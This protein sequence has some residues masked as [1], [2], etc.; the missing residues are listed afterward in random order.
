MSSPPTGP[1]GPSPRPPGP[2]TGRSRTGLVV[3]VV[4]LVVVIAAV[5]ALATIPVAHSDSY[6]F[7]SSTNSGTSVTSFNDSSARSICPSG[8]ASFTF[9]SSGLTFDAQVVNPAGSVVVTWSTPTFNDSFSIPSCGVYEVDVVGT[10]EGSWSM[11]V[12]VDYSAPIL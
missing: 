1:A 9:T 4:V 2:G 7:G 5:V 10:G 11:V 3:A 12:T 8:S 6:D